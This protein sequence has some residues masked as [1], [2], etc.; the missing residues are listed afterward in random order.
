MNNINL[1]APAE[2]SW[3]A[4]ILIRD[5][6]KKIE[7]GYYKV[8]SLEFTPQDDSYSDTEDWDVFCHCIDNFVELGKTEDLYRDSLGTDG[9]PITS[10]KIQTMDGNWFYI[11]G[12]LNHVTAQE[13][14]MIFYNDSPIFEV[15]K[16]RLIASG[17]AD[18]EPFHSFWDICRHYGA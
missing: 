6:L 16:C 2:F 13:D 18:D 11:I 7:R 1:K 9:N 10:W 3:D 17:P 15:I 4:K 12:K 5:I 14:I 8:S